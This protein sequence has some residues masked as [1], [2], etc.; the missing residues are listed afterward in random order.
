MKEPLD[1]SSNFCTGIDT[2]KSNNHKQNLSDKKEC[3]KVT[4][5]DC[6]SKWI[7]IIHKMII[8]SITLQFKIQYI[9]SLVD[10][11]INIVLYYY[12]LWL[13][14]MWFSKRQVDLQEKVKHL[15]EHIKDLDCC[16]RELAYFMIKLI[17]LSQDHQK[18]Y[19]FEY[20]ILFLKV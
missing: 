16:L 7:L 19:Y 5:E 15:E 8:F 13:Y 4:N 20:I 12:K 2:T 3:R 11:I 1:I 6:S 9:F 17:K 18:V 14:I 10:K